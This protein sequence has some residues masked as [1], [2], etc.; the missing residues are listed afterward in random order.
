MNGDFENNNGGFQNNGIGYG[1]NNGGFQDKVSGYGDN[2]SYGSPM[3][4][5]DF[6]NEYNSPMGSGSQY[7][8]NIPSYG[9]SMSFSSSDPNVQAFNSRAD[10]VTLPQSN[11]KKF[12]LPACIVGGLV[13][14]AVLGAVLLTV[15]KNAGYMSIKDFIDTPSGQAEMLQI[16]DSLNANKNT[17]Y[18]VRYYANDDNQF[19]FEYKFTRYRSITPSEQKAI[20]KELDDYMENN[21]HDA[22]KLIVDYTRAYKVRDF[23]I[24]YSFLNSDGSLIYDYEI[25]KSDY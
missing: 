12:I 3:R 5:S 16:E 8:D 14:L 17:N 23:T 15:I 24:V 19:V 21:K 13:L 22:A 2:N 20:K 25:K 10:V 4:A 11:K 9:Q 6:D 18:T 1:D 7:S